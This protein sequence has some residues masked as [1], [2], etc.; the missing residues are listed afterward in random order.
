[1]I[2]CCAETLK[3]PAAPD[4]L[5]VPELA[6]T[7]TQ[8]W[9]FCLEVQYVLAPPL[10]AHTPSGLASAAWRPALLTPVPWLALIGVPVLQPA[11]VWTPTTTPPPF[12]H[13]TAEPE[14]PPS[15]SIV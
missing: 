9:L 7:G 10:G 1:L 2:N 4:W 12:S 11:C 14:L 3:L 15:V 8:P 5:G 6:I 13:W